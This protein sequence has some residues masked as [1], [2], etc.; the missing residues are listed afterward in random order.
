MT[1]LGLSA[2]IGRDDGSTYWGH[3]QALM[4]EATMLDKMTQVWFDL[5]RASALRVASTATQHGAGGWVYNFEVE[6]DDPMGVTH[7]ADIPFFFDWTDPEN[8]IFFVH[9]A[10]D[11]ILT[12]ADQWSK[13]VV[14]FART[15]DPNGA[16]LPSWPKYGPDAFACLRIAHQPEIVGDP[17]GDMRQIYSVA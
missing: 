4:P 17:D 10:T 14:A 5:F 9:D 3:L 12:L 7:A 1:L 16:G 6:T 15:G 2:S 11:A 13:T 8:T